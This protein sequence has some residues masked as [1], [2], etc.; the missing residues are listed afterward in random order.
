[1]NMDNQKIQNPQN[2]SI[3]NEKTPS[4]VRGSKNDRDHLTLVEKQLQKEDYYFN[5]P[6]KF[7]HLKK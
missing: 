5:L 1:M 7:K 3:T 4:Y 2:R 6:D